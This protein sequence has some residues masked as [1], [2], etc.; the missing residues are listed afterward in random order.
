[1]GQIALLSPPYMY[2]I[3]TSSLL[4]QKKGEA[5]SRETYVTLWDNIGKFIRDKKIVVCSEIAHEIQD[6]E[7]SSWL[8]SLSCVIIEI[9]YEI[10]QNVTTVVTT[11]PKLINFNKRTSSGDA[12]LIATAMKYNL[13]IITEEKKTSPNKIP[14][15]CQSLGID[16]VSINELCGKEGWRF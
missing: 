14:Q 4:T 10:Q 5:Y 15:I 7:I 9:N 1:M 12:F 11:N 8:S 2:T 3:D 13:T 6:K 16:C